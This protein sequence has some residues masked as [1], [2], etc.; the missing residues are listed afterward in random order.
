MRYLKDILTIEIS[1]PSRWAKTGIHGVV[2]KAIFGGATGTSAAGASSASKA[3]V[4]VLLCIDV[5]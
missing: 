5:N 2:L 4:A 3:S 1:G